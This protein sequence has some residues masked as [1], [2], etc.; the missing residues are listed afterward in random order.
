M[1]FLHGWCSCCFRCVWYCCPVVFLLFLLLL[2]PLLLL[3]IG[4]SHG[5][6][7]SLGEWAKT[8]LP[9]SSTKL[10]VPGVGC[11]HHGST[12]RKHAGRLTNKLHLKKSS[13]ISQTFSNILKREINDAA[14]WKLGSCSLF[15]VPLSSAHLFLE[16]TSSLMVI[17][18]NK[19]H[20]IYNMCML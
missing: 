8:P 12:G 19:W 10:A 16:G 6:T 18:L 4:H 13:N 2:L 3:A 17:Q 20:V 9:S 15:S 11:V 5:I 14:L 7:S 1:S